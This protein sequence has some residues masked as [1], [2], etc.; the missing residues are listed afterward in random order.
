[1]TEGGEWHGQV[2]DRCGEST[3]DCEHKT[4]RGNAHPSGKDSV[5]E[6]VTGVIGADLANDLCNTRFFSSS[7][8]TSSRR[9]PSARG[10]RAQ[11]ISKE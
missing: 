8:M 2:S 1:V 5:C 7:V 6:S 10:A 11:W 4:D 3:Y 9:R